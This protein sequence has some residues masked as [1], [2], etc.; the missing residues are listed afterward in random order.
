MAD[1]SPEG[2]LALAVDLLSSTT[3]V[4]VFYTLIFV[5]YC[6]SFRL[7]YAQLRDDQGKLNRQ[8]LC[9]LVFQTV[10]LICATLDVIIKNRGVEVRYIDSVLPGGPL[11]PQVAA[12]IATLLQLDDAVSY[13]E[14]ALLLGMLASPPPVHSHA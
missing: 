14:D 1:D 10:L 7:C 8:T 2:H 13:L 3:V 9:T 11:S 12:K 4:A 6:L 5:L